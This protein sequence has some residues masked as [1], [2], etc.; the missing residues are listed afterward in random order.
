MHAWIYLILSGLRGRGRYSERDRSWPLCLER[1]SYVYHYN[2]GIY[3]LL[4]HFYVVL[5]EIE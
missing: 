5:I 2:Y 4:V 1:Y 3:L